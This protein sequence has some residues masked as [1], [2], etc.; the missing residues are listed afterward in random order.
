MVFIREYTDGDWKYTSSP[1]F[2]FYTPDP[3]SR[4]FHTTGVPVPY[5][6]IHLSHCI[7]VKESVTL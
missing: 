6:H 3:N 4:Y 2:L 5:F 7:D 1:I